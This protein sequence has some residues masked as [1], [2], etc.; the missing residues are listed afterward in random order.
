MN[1]RLTQKRAPPDRHR[2]TH[3]GPRLAVDPPRHHDHH[4]GREAHA[5]GRCLLGELHAA[6]ALFALFPE[7]ESLSGAD[8]MLFF[9]SLFLRICF[10]SLS[11]GHFLLFSLVSPPVV[12]VWVGE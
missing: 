4:S 2:K 6:A 7:R 10:D 11:I 1:T 9:L 8:C 5:G 3:L 12:G